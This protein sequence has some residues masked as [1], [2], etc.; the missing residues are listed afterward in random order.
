MIEGVTC[1]APFVRGDEH[2]HLAGMWA[3]RVQRSLSLSVKM[4]L[5]A[6]KRMNHWLENNAAST[7][8]IHASGSY[9]FDNEADA[10]LFYIAFR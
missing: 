8:I 1:S 4:I 9:S 6:S 2:P 5:H 10:V 7:P 3:V